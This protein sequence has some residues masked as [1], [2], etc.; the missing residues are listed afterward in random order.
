MKN[1]LT[2][3]ALTCTIAFFTSCKNNNDLGD[4]EINFK[5]AAADF[6]GD[7]D[8]HNVYYLD[9]YLYDKNLTDNKNNSGTMLYLALNCENTQIKY[10]NSG[11]Y[12]ANSATTPQTYTFERGVWNINA[13]TKVKTVAGSYIGIVKNGKIEEYK[14]IISGSLIIKNSGNYTISGFVTTEDNVRY[15]VSFNG[16]ISI[17]DMVVPLPETLTHGEI[18]YWGNIYNNNL[19]VFTIRLAADG[20]DLSTFSGSGDAMQIEFYTPPTSTTT[21]PNG[22]YPIKTINENIVNTSLAGEYNA[23]DNAD[24]G[25]V[26]YTSDILKVNQGYITITNK[27]GINYNL[28]L[29]F[30]DDYYGYSIIDN[31]NIDLPY[32]NRA[33]SAPKLSRVKS[34]NNS[35][36]TLQRSQVQ[37]TNKRFDRYEKSNKKSVSEMTKR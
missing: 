14:L 3:I 37:K 18:W 23:T 22:T 19:N 16:G 1:Y 4:R 36:T 32:V 11:T 17:V 30:K 34:T 31:F 7:P 12:N 25:T 27:G 6:Y 35:A 28:I 26:Y 29:N 21:I 9:L 20:V 8:W 2:L 13:D 24:Y 10:I 5:S 33:A 15:Q